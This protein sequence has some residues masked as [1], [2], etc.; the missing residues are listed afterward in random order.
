MGWFVFDLLNLSTTTIKVTHNVPWY[1]SGVVTSTSMTGSRRIGLAFLKGISHAENGGHLES[2]FVGVDLMVGAVGD[3]DVHIHNRVAGDR[4][5]W[6]WRCELRQDGVDKF[7][8]DSS[9]TTRLSD[10]EAF[11]FFVGCNIENNVSVL[12]AATGLLDEF[13][14]SRLAA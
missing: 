1:S 2:V 11:A 10:R 4:C 12:T 14:L 8:R 3:V 7:F 6:T 5:H 9:T 13:A